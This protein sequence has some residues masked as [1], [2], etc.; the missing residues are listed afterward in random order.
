[1]SARLSH[2]IFRCTLSLFVF[3]GVASFNDDEQKAISE[4]GKVLWEEAKK[5]GITMQSYVLFGRHTDAYRARLPNKTI[6]FTGLPRPIVSTSGSEW[7]LDDKWLLK[8]KL[9]EANIPVAPGNVCATAPDAIRIFNELERPVVVKPRVGSRGR[10]TATMVHTEGELREAFYRAKQ[11]CPWVVIEEH[12]VGAVYRGTA[13]G[14]KVVGV[15]A[16]EP[17]RVTGDGISTIQHLVK[18]KNSTRHEKVSEVILGAQHGVFLARSGMTT[19]SIPDK[20][21][22]IDLLEKIGVSYGGHSAE[23]TPSTH[24]EIIT[25][26]ERAAA[27]V[28][29]PIIGFDFIIADIARNPK[30]Q[31]WGIIECNSTPFINLHHDPVDGVPVNAAAPLWE[32]V[33][34]HSEQY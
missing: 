19:E 9:Q 32:Y 22:Q 30:E 26:I 29:D 5:R 34:E 20:G 28:A 16:G 31:K 7:W 11:L 1:M 15:L 23:V 3:M 8:E 21:V 25:E 4:R 24:P 14:G 33:M 10:H 18:S 17:P 13:I 6:V 12:L 27:A 2:A